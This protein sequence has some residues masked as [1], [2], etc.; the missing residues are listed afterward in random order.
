MMRTF[1]CGVG[2][3]LVVPEKSTGEVIDFLG[4]IQ[5]TAWVIGDI[6]EP[7]KGRGHFEWMD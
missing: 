5:E 4:G 6:A 2:M 7:K 3:V 1:N